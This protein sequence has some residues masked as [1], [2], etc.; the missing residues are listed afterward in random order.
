MQQLVRGLPKDGRESA[1][2]AILKDTKGNGWS[3]PQF[4][5][6][7]WNCGMVAWGGDHH[8]A[9]SKER[10]ANQG[11]EAESG[12]KRHVGQGF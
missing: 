1:N 4:S 10:R 6:E 12:H 2:D 5:T 8:L 11:K 7:L 9:L 3:F